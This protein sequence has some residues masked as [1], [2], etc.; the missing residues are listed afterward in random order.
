MPLSDAPIQQPIVVGGLTSQPWV[1]FFTA[2]YKAV[3]AKDIE[4]QGS[5]NGLILESPNGTR[6]RVTVS[7]AGALVVTA[8]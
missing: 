4:I 6:Y 3:Y 7:N 5:A 8:V 2:I 1:R